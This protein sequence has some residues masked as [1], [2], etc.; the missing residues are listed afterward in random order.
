[1]AERWLPDFGEFF[2]SLGRLIQNC[3]VQLHSASCNTSEFLFRRLDEYERTLSTLISRYSESYGHIPSE[4]DFLAN[5]SHLLNR[6]STLRAYFERNCFLLNNED[7]NLPNEGRSALSESNGLPGRPRL[8]IIRDQLE[9]LH[10][11]CRFQWSE[12]CR[13]L[14]VSD[15]TL[16]RRR[17]E[18][19]MQVEG[20]VYSNISD[21]EL[22][23]IV[24][25]ILLLTPAAGLRMVQGAL[26][27]QGYTI[28]R[29][30]VLQSLRRVDPVTS[31]LRNARRVI[32]RHYNVACSNDLW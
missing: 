23:A 8:S 18:F 6:T 32:R 22:D 5:L 20:R 10:G 7:E 3:E 26:I 16:R 21:D 29:D 19:G 28:Q 12:I 11:D 31:T 14:G 25:S 9:A 17:H 2:L 27:Q 30:R 4:Q 15:R 24:R 1:M 13:L